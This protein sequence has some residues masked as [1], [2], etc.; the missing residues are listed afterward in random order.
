MRN[1]ELIIQMVKDWRMHGSAIDE[2]TDDRAAAHA[3]ALA[4][5]LL[6]WLHGTQPSEAQ[7]VV[8]LRRPLNG[9]EVQP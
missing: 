2:I 9:Y 4:L 1:P 6:T 8:N 5:A 3:F 7:T